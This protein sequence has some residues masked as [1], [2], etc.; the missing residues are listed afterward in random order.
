MVA[1]EGLPRMA[2]SPILRQ[3]CDITL[4]NAFQNSFLRV[5]A[6]FRSV[7]GGTV[8][9][10]SETPWNTFQG[11]ERTRRERERTF[12]H[13]VTTSR[14]PTMTQSDRTMPVNACSGPVPIG[15]DAPCSLS[16]LGR[17][18]RADMRKPAVLDQT[19]D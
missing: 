6:V 16:G 15:V 19:V 17:E 5:S 4:E 9:R 12:R 14:V 10:P 3:T 13:A 8:D 2:F 18:G 1:F 7:C 11:H